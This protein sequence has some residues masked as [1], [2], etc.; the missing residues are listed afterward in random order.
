MTAYQILNRTRG[1]VLA[2]Q[3]ELAETAATRTRG[4]LG[5][6]GLPEGGGLIIDPCNAIHT[7]FMRFTIDVL[8]VTADG[9]VVRVLEQLVPWRLTRMYFRAR[10]VVELPAGTLQRVPCQPGDQLE[11]VLLSTPR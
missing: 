2:Q 1:G 9:Q 6:D 3:A 8:F 10:K 4:L 7:F 11:F 5:R